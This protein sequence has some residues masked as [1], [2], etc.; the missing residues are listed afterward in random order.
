M[1]GGSKCTQGSGLGVGDEP[2]GLQEAP[3]SIMVVRRDVTSGVKI[4]S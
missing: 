3:A 2:T 4:S 1:L